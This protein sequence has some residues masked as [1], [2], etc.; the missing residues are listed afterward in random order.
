MN[1]TL[2]ISIGIAICLEAFFSGSELG[3]ISYDRIRLKNEVNKNK[4]WA[5]IV[6]SLIKNPGKLFATTL[7]GTNVCEITASTLFS[8]FIIL[9]FG[10]E[11][12]YLTLIIIFPFVLLCGEIIPKIYFKKNAPILL[13]IL[14]VP[15]WIFSI[16]FRPFTLIF[17]RISSTMLKVFH[18]EEYENRFLLTKEEL[19]LIIRRDTSKSDVKQSERK[20]IERILTFTKTSAKEV[21]IP[22]ID[23]K[24]I[25]ITATID[26]AIKEL[27]VNGFSRYPVYSERIDNIVGMLNIHELLFVNREEKNIQKY[28]HEINYAPETHPIDKL[29]VK[30]Q[31]E[32]SSM[33]TVVDEY[34]GCIG[35]ITLEDILEEIVGNID[36]EYD[37]EE[38]LV[39]SLGFDTFLINARASIEDLNEQ[40]GFKIPEGDYETL[41]GFILHILK[42]IPVQGESFQHKGLKITIKEASDKAIEKVVLIKEQKEE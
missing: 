12:E 23:V 16:I 13:P 5:K 33:H 4:K 36:D 40:H 41:A 15:L 30:M 11:Y 37:A 8:L 28:V 1:T 24:A 35:I 6:Y 39:K 21:M 17:S 42:R 20:M 3:I 25:S 31:H 34:G 14:A 7:F 29:L 22:L 32:G 10:S 27:E 18:A 2:L 19:A 9:N 26:D 38:S